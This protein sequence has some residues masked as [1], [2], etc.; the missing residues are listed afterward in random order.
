M[1]DCVVHLDTE[2]GP[3]QGRWL[4]V[5][6]VAQ[7][8]NTTCTYYRT[9]N[10]QKPGYRWRGEVFG[11]R[12]IWAGSDDGESELW[13]CQQC[14]DSMSEVELVRTRHSPLALSRSC[15]MFIF[16]I[17]G[18]LPRNLEQP[19]FSETLH[20]YYFFLTSEFPGLFRSFFS[21]CS[22][23]FDQQSLWSFEVDVKA[24]RSKLTAKVSSMIIMECFGKLTLS[25]FT[26]MAQ[27]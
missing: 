22:A 4:D 1:N 14:G 9:R 16:E 3:V 20:T 26:L 2:H 23:F 7:T 6:T 17:E 11:W 19:A 21:D 27:I 24:R 10:P 13:Q 5:W 8:L 15:H 12:W 25:V 18:L